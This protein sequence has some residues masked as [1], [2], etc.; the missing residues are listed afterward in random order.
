[1]FFQ[2]DVL[3]TTW[4]VTVKIT[5]L[6]QIGVGTL[7]NVILFF[8]NVSTILLDQRQ[9]PTHMILTHV[10]MANVLILLSSG[11]PH[12]MVAFALRKP[13]STLGCKFSYYIHRVACHGSL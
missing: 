10:S 12:T 11:I 1:M 5:F 6:L 9:R 4:E 3:R 2:K 13:L 8:Y 7:A